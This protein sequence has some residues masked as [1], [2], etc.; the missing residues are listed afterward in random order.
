MMDIPVVTQQDLWR[1]CLSYVSLLFV[2]E[3]AGSRWA[4][5]G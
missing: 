3:L 5:A 4:R 2:S 1:G